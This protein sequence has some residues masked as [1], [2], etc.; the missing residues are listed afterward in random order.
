KLANRGTTVL[1]KKKKNF[2]LSKNKSMKQLKWFNKIAYAL[3][4]M[5]VVLTLMGYLLSSMAPKLFPFL[6]VLT[7]ILPTILILNLVFVV[8]WAIQFKKQV[9]LSVVVF[10]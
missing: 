3:N 8:Y 5:L 1:P 2:C 9:F 4:I 6:S 10:L 7:L